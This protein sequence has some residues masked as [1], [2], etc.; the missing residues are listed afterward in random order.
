MDFNEKVIE[1]FTNP[2]NVG[3]IEN[4]GGMGKAT[5]PICGDITQISLHIENDI[6]LDAKFKTFGCG[7]A[8]ASS[9][10]AT[11]M[12][13][14]KTIQEALQV[15]NQAVVNALGGLPEEKVHC[16]CLAEEAIHGALRDY[17]LKN[18]IVIEGL[19]DNGSI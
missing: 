15:T 1:H 9:S 16:S 12:L 18:G 7:A 6:I 4:A 14:G 17:A 3:E 8:V 10:M 11:E 2:R 13:I 5:S 19:S